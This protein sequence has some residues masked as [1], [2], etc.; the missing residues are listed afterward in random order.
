ML[1]L[2]TPLRTLLLG[3][4]LHTRFVVVRP[5]T[6]YHNRSCV[7]RPVGRRVHRVDRSLSRRLE[8]TR[9]FASLGRRNTLKALKSRNRSR[10]STSLR[11]VL[12]RSISPREM[13]RCLPSPFPATACHAWALTPPHRVLLGHQRRDAEGDPAH[14]T[15]RAFCPERAVTVA[16]EVVERSPIPLSLT[17]TCASVF[18]KYVRSATNR[19]RSS[20]FV[21]RSAACASPARLC[22]YFRIYLSCNLLQALLL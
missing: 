12:R 5:V 20:G 7:A 13:L 14:A 18:I 10:R 9:D 6:R 21:S 19:F 17:L 1:L 8:G 2:S 16:S 22:L 3:R 4:I 11:E 15:D